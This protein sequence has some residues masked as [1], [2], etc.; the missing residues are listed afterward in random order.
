V[1][2]LLVP[3]ICV[4]LACFSVAL[5]VWWVAGEWIGSL[6]VKLLARWVEPL[7]LGVDLQPDKPSIAR[8][9]KPEFTLKDLLVPP[10]P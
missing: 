6:A 7:Q 2:E 10:G 4:C 8:L 9:S 3:N 1:R 5:L